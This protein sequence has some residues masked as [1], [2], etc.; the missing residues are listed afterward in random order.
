MERKPNGFWN[1]K[2]NVFAEAKKYKTKRKF[3]KNCAG[4]Y[5]VARKNGWFDEMD[6]F[7]ETC[8]PNGFW[9]KERVFAE[10]KKYKTRSEF[11]K[12]CIRAY[13]LA[14]KNK[15]FDEMDW[16]ISTQKSPGYWNIKENTF[17]EAKKYK[18]RNEFRKYSNGAYAASLKNDWIDEMEWLV[19]GRVKQY[20]D[21][22]DCVYKY[23]FK[24]TNSIYI[25]RTIDKNQRDNQHRTRERDTLYR[26]AK[27]NG[28]EVPAMDIIEDNLTIEEGLDREDYWKNYYKDRGYNVLNTAKTGIGS[29][30]IGA[31]AC[32]KWNKKSVFEVSKKYKSKIEFRKSCCSAYHVAWKRNW[33]GE[34]DWLVRPIKIKWTKEN[35]FVEAK[36]YQTRTQFQKV[37]GS[38]YNVALRNNWLNEMSWFVEGKRSNG[39]WTKENV[40]EEAKKYQTRAQFAK[41]CGSA[42]EVSRKN[43]WLDELFP[44]AA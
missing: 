38:A 40:F 11:R 18:T 39:F 10:A 15:W 32:G 12:Y 21:K 41:D 33:F 43:G 16:F 23:Y 36:K 27:A 34:M 30:S 8:K 28:L 44:K 37:C 25:G 26:Y 31:I 6:W 9:T 24:E 20:T 4:G 29:G 7:E 14:Y 3:E 22:K 19:D 1:I 35:V 13:D 42:Y 2:E 5:K 17:T